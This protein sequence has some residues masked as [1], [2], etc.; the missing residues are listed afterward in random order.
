MV[1]SSMLAYHD[2]GTAKPYI[3]LEKKMAESLKETVKNNDSMLSSRLGTG[4]N[5]S[6]ATNTTH[7]REWKK[8]TFGKFT[9]TP[10]TKP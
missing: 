1:C 3:R 7:D 9:A 4:K 2:T 5:F 10:M 8:K 6:R